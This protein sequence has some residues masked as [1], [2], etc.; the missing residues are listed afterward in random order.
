MSGTP[1]ADLPHAVAVIGL[2]GRFPGAPDIDAFWQNLRA[3]RDGIARFRADE[4]EAAG[5]ARATFEHPDYV[6]A[7][8]I[9]DDIDC[10]DADLFGISA[11]EAALIDPQHRLFLECAWTALEGAGY[12]PG[13]KPL[14]VGVFA[15]ASL[16]SYLSASP[17][18]LG[19]GRG[20]AQLHSLIGNDKDY[21]TTR[22]SHRLNLTGP[23]IG[24]QT[25]CSTSLVAV[26]L[27]CQSLVSGECDMALAG[28]VSISIP[29]TAGYRYQDGLILS[30]DGR[31]RPFD[32]AA[33][34]TLGGNG[35]GVVLLKPLAQAL[36]DGDPIRA[37]IRG[38]AVN[39]DGSD[40]VGYAAPSVAGQMRVVREAL[41]LAELSAASIGYVEAHGTGT[42]LGDPIEVE[43][44]TRAFAV[45]E[46]GV[47][48]LGSVKSN[49]GHLD[50]AAGI[51]SLIKTVLALEAG[52][53]PPTLHYERPNARIDFLATPFFVAKELVP[54]PERG[55][56]RRAGVSSFGFGGTNA[57]L[58]L[59]QAPTAPCVRPNGSGQPVLLV[60]SASSR[61]QVEQLARRYEA[62]LI[63]GPAPSDLA[64]TA[65]LHRRA[66]PARAA[67]VAEGGDA[68]RT[69][70]AGLA[71]REGDAEVTSGDVAAGHGGRIAFQ[72]SGQG[73]LSAGAA[74]GLY[75]RFP[76][77][78]AALDAHLADRAPGVRAFLLDARTEEAGAET[79]QSALL[80]YQ[81]A[82]VAVWRA[83]GIRPSA[84][85]GHSI[86][87]MAAAVV[88]GAL[89]GTDVSNLVATRGRLT[90]ELVR[91]GVMHAVLA[92]EEQ[93][94]A[95]CE[96]QSA[97]VAIAA[98]NGPSECVVAGDTAV[99]D[100]LV[101]GFERGGITTRRLAITHPFHAPNVTPMLPALL[102]AARSL[103]VQTPDIPFVS[104]RYGRGLQSGERLDAAY[105]AAHLREPV[106]YADALAAL[107][108]PAFDLI[109]EI[110]PRSTLTKLGQRNRPDARFVASAE[111]GVDPV[112]SILRA[113]GH[114]FCVGADVA[115]GAL[116]D[117]HP[118]HPRRISAPTYPF[119]RD[120]HWHPGAGRLNGTSVQPADDTSWT[121]VVAAAQAQSAAGSPLIEAE[122]HAAREAAVEALS[123]AGAARAFAELGF[124][125]AVRKPAS[126]DTIA[127][128]LGI[129]SRHR[130]LAR[131]LL[132]GLVEAGRLSVDGDRFH[133]LLAPDEA[134]I[135]KLR[136]Q[137][138]AA[139]HAWPAM[140]QITLD[141]L[142]RFAAALSGSV[143][144]RE[145]LFG[146][147]S[148]EAARAVYSEMPNAR[149]FNG[150]LREAVRAF[151]E[152]WPR[153]RA[154]RVL[155]IGGGT[156]ATTERLLP[157]LPP[158][159]ARYVFTDVS[160]LF[161]RRAETRFSDFPFLTTALL[162]IGRPPAEQGFEPA[163]FDLIVAANVL[164]VA[165][166]LGGA[167]EHVRWLLA[168]GG[169]ALA[170]EIVRPTMIGEITT[171]LLLP[172]IRD[173][174]RRGIQ[175]MAS[176]A[177]WRRAFAEAGFDEVAVLPSAED[178][179]A[180]LPERVLMARADTGETAGRAEPVRSDIFYRTE[181]DLSAPLLAPES[182]AGEEWILAADA[183]ERQDNL[184]A[185]IRR[186]GGRVIVAPALE[187]PGAVAQFARSLDPAPG[188]RRFVD[189][190][191][192]DRGK[193]D[194][195]APSPGA[196]QKQLC[197][198]LLEILAGFDTAGVA[199][200]DLR[201]V[202]AG[203]QSVRPD[204]RV[205]IEAAPLWGM[206]RVVALG[207][208]E[209]GC[210]QIDVDPTGGADAE[211]LL[212]ALAA[213]TT[214]TLLVLRSASV[215]VPR[216]RRVRLDALP[217]RSL[218]V[219]PDG[220]HVI[221][222]G[223]GGLGLTVARWLLDRGARHIA[224]L[225]RSEPDARRSAAIRAIAAKGCDIRVLR[226]DIID[227]PRVE[228]AFG[229]LADTGLP[230]R[231]IFHCA[232]ARSVGTDSGGWD[233]FHAILAP[234]VEGAWTL[235]E[236]SL[237]R[238]LNL[239]AFVLFSSS[240]SVA[241]AFGM[242]DY[243]AANTFLDAL[244]L[245]R[246]ALGL[247]ALSVSWGAWRDV[248]AVADPA[249]AEH[250]RRGGLRSFE[251]SHA[252]ALLDAALRREA[253][254]LAILD[255]DWP[256]MLRQYGEGQ[257]PPVFADV[258]PASRP[259]PPRAVSGRDDAFLD[260]LHSMSAE[261]RPEALRSWLA[262]AFGALL[263]RPAAAIAPDINLIETGVDS[264]MF[265]EM[266]S[267][268]GIRL[269]L[270]L[271]PSELLRHFTIAAM[272]ERILPML[273]AAAPEPDE[274]SVASLLVHRPQERFAPFPLTDVQ[275]AYWIGRR[276]ELDLGNTACQGYTELDC[277]DL[278]IERLEAAWQRVAARH[279][280]LRVV[281]LPEGRQ[282][283]IEAPDPYRIPVLDLRDLSEEARV[284]RLEALRRTLSHRVRPTDRWPLWDVQITR[285][286]ARRSRLHVGIDNVAIDG[287]SIGIVL[288]EWIAFYRDPD[289]DL[290]APSLSFR[291]YVLAFE[292][293][294][295]TPGYGRAQRYWQA[296]LTDLP[297][298]PELPLVR[299]P[300][301][302]GEPRFVRHSLKM[303]AD[304]WRR[305]KAS[306]G[307][308]GLTPAGLLLAAYA[309]VLA[310]WS[311]SPRLTINA[312]VFTRL[313][314]AA[315]INDVVGEFTSNI[316]V[317][318][319]MSG[320]A[321]FVERAR[322]VQAQLFRD[323]E[324]GAVSG[325][326]VVRSMMRA[327]ADARV[328]AM[329]VVFTSTFGLALDADTSY[330]G[331]VS[332]FSAFGREVFSISQTPQVWLD[333]HVHDLDG[334][335]GVNWDVVEGLFA[336][337]VIEAMFEA[338]RDLLERLAAD[339]SGAADPSSAD[340][341]SAPRPLR[342]PPAQLAARASL[343]D[344]AAD[345]GPDALLHAGILEQARA[346]PERIALVDP[347]RTLTY[348][349]LVAEAEA[350]AA[351]LDACL[352]PPRQAD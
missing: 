299:D 57:H 315:D 238:N 93:V 233:A 31:C 248:G 112:V 136:V 261:E 333:N 302:I 344:T 280:M 264:L 34:G 349:R 292:D 126:A 48:A 18:D 74:V 46:R 286:D 49:L 116:Y 86:G 41:A 42:A 300:A 79:L 144:P 145:I 163:S 273:L 76:A 309:E 177:V 168:E 214:E 88:S 25:A 290:P 293:Y 148:A 196:V 87:E 227:R 272:A 209:L 161:L 256:R 94:R 255:A 269:G 123:A 314:V 80:A 188:R 53:V 217:K 221:A 138:E 190:R 313:P 335:L 125:D 78:R 23:S 287:R 157:L 75:A 129:A 257:I 102:E 152:A 297:T 173:T 135:A 62:A 109:L 158:A 267:D 160:P 151:V 243:V 231:S 44:L 147:G 296:R 191:S 114:L 301:T 20:A 182:L 229:T 104:S 204:D 324:H 298:A 70:L 183:S 180:C 253:A 162:D 351:E 208:P 234:K 350:L 240:V 277:L 345:L 206:A 250:L 303:E 171:G 327:G 142:D 271:S 223:L 262:D 200:G 37:V 245:E 67:I 45:E 111:G 72:F 40:K 281:V 26:H 210:R 270:T 232:V 96:G 84:V 89:S 28:G 325:I 283:I 282:Q 6:P 137:A 249:H 316:L 222:G 150:I 117:G 306:G 39:N 5:V 59:E 224:I 81:L 318:C 11:H 252:I 134:E 305:L 83:F 175:P 184:A 254:H 263:N 55:G 198:G 310:R 172:E 51:A 77:F 14:A 153:D 347:E 35:V 105:W 241:P 113:L 100:R 10:F 304:A 54:W 342:L 3:G 30:P 199:P 149:Y 288:S 166:D 285:L 219:A 179:S 22:T 340:P 322:A 230:I 216:L 321:P 274:P 332:A 4:L 192:I 71:A 24:V 2:A 226:A 237:A 106:R 128:A 68:L 246:R 60:L 336:P 212:V 326:E 178:P 265:I 279:E 211:R 146:D 320:D 307:R 19:S 220:W 167:L 348:A 27:A 247:P 141:A 139:W 258:L 295:R 56:L 21:L 244:A 16:G 90:A 91:P 323:I 66:F 343:N 260:R 133:D 215:F 85:L 284:T 176:E 352:G 98:V 207:H 195:S 8:G 99:I 65:A 33:G 122:H 235:H 278:D 38:S 47:C 130:Q 110:G 52:V 73:G 339:T 181:W 36:A 124:H 189:L 329:P 201:I 32:A 312:P 132:D 225:A 169:L 17:G 289:G 268:F 50:A 1:I 63:A 276:Q 259:A 338:Y 251:P 185:E 120:R 43:A 170:Y 218:T 294:R 131:R 228:D 103:A 82:L 69:G 239:D 203:S 107:D 97:P 197:G 194:A 236:I 61:E 108:P 330:A 242:P 311:K 143:D 275:Q 308:N 331:N 101:A 64:L 205:A 118:D 165:P 7:G 337:G 121:D 156:A 127:E 213:E 291:D 154:L 159:R 92:S 140:R 164:H 155:E 119:A 9:L 193:S 317:G 12:P 341:W 202:T 186:R 266:A 187:D 115:W 29:Q 95:A 328:G 346:T 58:V 334:G 15:G 319:D 13:K 174:D